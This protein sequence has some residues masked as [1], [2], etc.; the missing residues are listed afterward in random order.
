MNRLAVRYDALVQQMGGKAV[1]PHL[2]PRIVL[3]TQRRALRHR[4]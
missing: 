3:C 2:G 1:V 4:P